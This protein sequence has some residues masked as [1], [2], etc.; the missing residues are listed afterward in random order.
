MPFLHRPSPLASPIGSRSCVC[1]GEYADRKGPWERAAR[2]GKNKQGAVGRHIT[3]TIRRLDDQTENRR[4]T[5]TTHP[6]TIKLAGWKRLSL[7]ILLVQAV[8][9]VIGLALEL[10]D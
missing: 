4:L 3:P 10:A 5:R 7:K 1:Q 6:T 2:A 9:A 8:P